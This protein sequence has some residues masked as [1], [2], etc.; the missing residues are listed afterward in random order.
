MSG[1]YDL[2]VEP[3]NG[4][5]LFGMSVEDEVYSISFVETAVSGGERLLALGDGWNRRAS[6][7]AAFQ[8][9]NVLCALSEGDGT[10]LLDDVLSRAHLVTECDG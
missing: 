10:P 5:P 6:G 7:A 8:E 2:L 9:S 4:M 1:V 3:H